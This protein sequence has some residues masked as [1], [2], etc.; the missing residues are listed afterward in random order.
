[1]ITARLHGREPGDAPN[2][3][4]PSQH[5]LLLSRLAVIRDGWL[6]PGMLDESMAVGHAARSLVQFIRGPVMSHARVEETVD[7]ALHGYSQNADR[8]MSGSEREHEERIHRAGRSAGSGRDRDGR[9]PPDNQRDRGG[10]RRELHRVAHRGPR[11][12]EQRARRRARCRDQSRPL[13][14]LRFRRRV[15]QLWD[16]PSPW[17]NG[18]AEPS[19]RVIHFLVPGQSVAAAHRL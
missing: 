1:M 8:S 12:D 17:T 5:D 18:S 13:R 15:P 9:Q 3:T 14:H 16:R 6:A 4:R 19:R 7:A 11:R 10:D 2:D